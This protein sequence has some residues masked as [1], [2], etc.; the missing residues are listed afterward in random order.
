MV[1]P[2]DPIGEVG[3]NYFYVLDMVKLWCPSVGPTGAPDDL[4]SSEVPDD[5]P[6]SLLYGSSF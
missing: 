3:C 6:I 5:V 2:H 1:S 4:E